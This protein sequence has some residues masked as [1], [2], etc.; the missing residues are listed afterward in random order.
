MDD[1]GDGSRV[2]AADGCTGTGLVA[3]APCVFA[4]AVATAES[5][6]SLSCKLSRL[7]RPPAPAP[8][9][10]KLVE[11]LAM[12]DAACSC[13]SAAFLAKSAKDC[14]HMLTVVVLLQQ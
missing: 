13:S 3:E 10:G 2:A 11:V 1:G 4:V 5:L 7:K 12:D 9:E 8:M 6:S 14:P